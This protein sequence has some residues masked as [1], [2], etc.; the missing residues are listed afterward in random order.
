M[1]SSHRFSFKKVDPCEK[2]VMD[3]IYRL[4]FEVYSQQCN[5]IREEDFPQKLECDEYD[6]HSIHFV[7]MDEDNVVVATSRMI[8]NTEKRSPLLELFPKLH[9]EFDVSPNSITEISRL[10]ISK[11]LCNSNMKRLKGSHRSAK[12][13]DYGTIV[14]GLCQKMFEETTRL[15][16]THW[17]AL[18][19][20]GLLALLR[21]YG[22]KMIC[23]G[24]VV[25][26]FG[27]VRPYIGNVADMEKL[28]WF[29]HFN[30]H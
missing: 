1:T 8:L 12:L 15:G 11:R 2:H 25:D 17:C 13:G 19:E 4:R 29:S 6:K 3:A 20:K 5:F 28:W 10:L 14:Y 9:N 30:I 21:I 22:F 26:L 16:I 27:P 7:A 18:M 24:D 23:V